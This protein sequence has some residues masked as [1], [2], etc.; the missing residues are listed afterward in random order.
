MPIG[1]GEAAGAEEGPDA[2]WLAH[3][4]V[5]DRCVVEEHD[6]LVAARHRFEPDL[7]RLDL[8][9][10][11]VVDLPQRRLAEVRDLG[12][13]KA[14]DEALRPDDADLDL[15][16][17]EHDVVAIEHDD[18]AGTQSLRDLVGAAGVMV[19][20]SE[21]RDDGHRQARTCLREDARLLRE[22]VRREVAREQHE[23]DVLRDGRE[24]ARQPFAQVLARVHVAGGSD[25]D[26]SAHPMHVPAREVLRTRKTGTP[27]R[28]CR[29][30]LRRTSNRCS[31]R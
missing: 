26:G 1:S 24:R 2:L 13:G 17:L 3:D 18:V 27:R 20:V 15:T 28:S 29:P 9:R 19:V 14:A 16:Q 23:I 30:H 25:A 11:L 21:Y 12:T 10:G 5:G 22:A 7:E 4:G 31:P 8:E 6:P